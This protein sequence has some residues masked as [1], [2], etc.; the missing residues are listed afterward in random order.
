MG[1]APGRAVDHSGA[2][3]DESGLRGGWAETALTPGGHTVH[4]TMGLWEARLGEGVR[5]LQ[6]SWGPGGSLKNKINL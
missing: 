6:G 1:L 2:R 4:S 3:S 5:D